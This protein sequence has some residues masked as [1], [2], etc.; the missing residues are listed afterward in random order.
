MLITLSLPSA[1]ANPSTAATPRM[2]SQSGLVSLPLAAKAWVGRVRASM[3]AHTS[4][5]NAAA[6]RT[7]KNQ[8]RMLNELNAGTGS[9]YLI[10]VGAGTGGSPP[11]GLVRLPGIFQIIIVVGAQLHGHG[12]GVGFRAGRPAGQRGRAPVVVG[13]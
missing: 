8:S 2:M 12:Q 3:K 10:A 6:D 4:T 7:K 11:G 9:R 5:T 1:P 13:R